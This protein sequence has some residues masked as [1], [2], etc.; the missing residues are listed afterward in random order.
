MRGRVI[1]APE[2]HDRDLLIS[3][4]P[5]LSQAERDP[6]PL[7]SD[8]IDQDG[9]WL[10]AALN[11]TLAHPHWNTSRRLAGWAFRQ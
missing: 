4:T 5:E 2:L 11:V 9:T 7:I 1:D 6:Q 10:T 3:V 8:G